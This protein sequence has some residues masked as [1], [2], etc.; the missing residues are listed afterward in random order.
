MSF[1]IELIVQ[2]KYVHILLTLFDMSQEY[3][4]FFLVKLKINAM[5]QIFPPS[6]INLSLID[7]WLL[8]IP[9]ANILF[10]FSLRTSLNPPN[11]THTI[12]ISRAFS[13]IT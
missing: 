8:N 9:A 11:M 7:C 2:N 1:F 3:F 4:I 6:K 12:V 13:I 5:I 10:K